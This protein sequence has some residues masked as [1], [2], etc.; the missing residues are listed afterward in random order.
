[1]NGRFFANPRW[2]RDVLWGNDPV[3]RGK[4]SMMQRGWRS[5]VSAR[6]VAALALAAAIAWFPSV[7]AAEGAKGGDSPK[8]ISSGSVAVRL[9]DV[10]LLDQDGRKVRFRTD[11]IGDRIVVIDTFF[12]TCT[13]ICPILGAIFGDLQEQ[14]GDRLDREVRLISISVDPQT[15]IP[16]RLKKYAEQWEARPGWLFLTGEE[17]VVDRVLEGIG[18]YSPDFSDHPSAFLVGD[19]RTG[20]WTRFYGFATPEQLKSRV[21]ELLAERRGKTPAR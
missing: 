1:M 17:K 21:E 5:V 12:T 15:D 2:G 10:P 16:P 18:M 3:V 4:V 8:E 7:A 14:L 20:K 11:A 9:H 19:G 13:L 6:A